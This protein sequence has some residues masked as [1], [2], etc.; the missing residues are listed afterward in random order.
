MATV[1]STKIAKPSPIVEDEQGQ[2]RARQGISREVVQELSKVK[3]EPDWMAEKRLR[4]LE[5]FERKPMPK[6]GVDLSGLDLDDLVLYSPP[7]AGRYNSWDEVPEEMKK[8]YEDLGI[9]QAEREHLAGVVGVWRQEPV[10]EGLK[11]EYRKLGILFCSMDTAISEYPELVQRYFMNKCVPPQDNKFSALHGA[12][13]SGG[14]FLYV[15]KGVKVD[16][17]LQAY[18]RMEGAGEGT[19]EHTLI[20]ADEGSDVNYIEGCHPAGEQVVVGDRWVNIESLSPGDHVVGDDGRKHEVLAAMCRHHKGK[21]VTI[22]PLS[23]YNSFKLTPNHPVKIVRRELVRNANARDGR[24]PQVSTKR[25]LNIPPQYV[26]AGEVRKGDFLVFP[27]VKPTTATPYSQEELRLLGYYLAEGSAFVHKALNQPVVSFSFGSEEHEHVAAVQELIEAITGKR[28]Y[29]V[30]DKRAKGVN[31][32]VYS[33]EL[34]DMCIEACGKGAATKRLSPEL[35]ECDAEAL[36]PLLEAYFAGDGNVLERPGGAAPLHRASTASETLARQLQEILARSG[37]FASIAL[38]EGGADSSGDRQIVREDELVIT[39]T[40]ARTQGEVR[41]ADEYFLVPVKEVASEDYDD[42]VFNI[43][44]EGVN[45]YLARGFAVHNCTAQ[46]YSVNSMHSAV[47]EIFVHEG[48]KARYTTVQ[49]W[50]KDVYN[51]NTKRAI[52]DAEGT[53]EWV[54]GSMGA[55]YVMDHLNVGVASGGVHKDTG[56]KVVHQAPNTTSNILAKSISKDGGIMGY[57]GLVKMGQRAHGSKARVQCDG[58]M[59]DG[60]SRSDTW[61]DIQIQ[62]PHVTVAHEATVG[63][64]SD[65]QLFYMGSRGFTEDEAAAMIVNGF[66]EP[67]TKELPMEYAVELNRLIQLE[68]VGSIG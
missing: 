33:R 57:R 23:K 16:L 56:A 55:K 31:V 22:T 3:G 4:S 68:M 53:V 43:E 45:S 13:W 11:E 60:I 54:G 51:L 17:P 10:Y 61:P 24:L 25:L 44:V 66:I 59:M 50:S 21:M 62:N 19:F 52:V 5:I 34:M 15:P 8:T 64:I 47:V 48:A 37:H 38:R 49:N 32:T 65:D 20:I 12:V 7:T 27:R 58:L 2:L 41:I 30:R 63:R 28:A 6:W 35:A 67:V 1:D 42:M 9:P 14:S 39:Y 26:P 46:T 40:P 36:A 18:F 29:A